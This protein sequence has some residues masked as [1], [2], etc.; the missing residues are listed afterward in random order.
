MLAQLYSGITFPVHFHFSTTSQQAKSTKTNMSDKQL[1]FVGHVSILAEKLEDAMTFLEDCWDPAESV[2]WDPIESALSC[3]ETL[4]DEA[5][6]TESVLRPLIERLEDMAQED[7]SAFMPGWLLRL[8]QEDSIDM[9]TDIREQLHE[10]GIV[11]WKTVVRLWEV[12]DKAAYE[13][14]HRKWTRQLIKLDSRYSKLW[15]TAHLSLAEVK[16]AARYHPSNGMDAV[17]SDKKRK[18]GSE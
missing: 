1:K 9:Y 15:D 11:G 7:I 4:V 3:A 6:K 18:L 13:Y 16:A 2:G 14:L 5:P 10:M 17:V 12:V 8:E